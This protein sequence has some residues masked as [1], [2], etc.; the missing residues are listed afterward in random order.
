[1]DV[2][3]DWL[4]QV[5]ISSGSN[6]ASPQVAPFPQ[7][8]EHH[9]VDASN[10]QDE[11]MD[12]VSRRVRSL[13][14]ASIDEGEA[15]TQ[16]GLAVDDMEGKKVKKKK[17]TKAPEGASSPIGTLV[18]N[19]KQLLRRRNSVNGSVEP[20]TVLP[21]VD[22][23]QGMEEPSADD[24]LPDEEEDDSNRGT[25]SN[26]ART[27]SG[28]GVLMLAADGTTVRRRPD[29]LQGLPSPMRSGM[30][31]PMVGPRVYASS[32]PL[33]GS[34]DDAGTTRR[35]GSKTMLTSS[36]KID[37]AASL[38]SKVRKTYSS[39]THGLVQCLLLHW[40]IRLTPPCFL[41]RGT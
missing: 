39:T 18:S 19:S 28:S 26:M 41:C 14:L 25:G 30:S 31:S 20:D 29:G 37:S 24:Y 7:P 17:K 22:D 10:V 8:D 36:P 16:A 33:S 1:M 13:S 38:A 3:S 5:P 34:V 12:N 27:E 23:L 2:H 15:L 21:H 9:A 4:P 11:C 6:P 40:V 35:F 32:T